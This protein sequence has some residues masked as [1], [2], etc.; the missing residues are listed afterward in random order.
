MALAVVLTADCVGQDAGFKN[1]NEQNGL[2]SSEVYQVFQDHEGF[3]W[4]ATDNGVV[5]FDGGEFKLFN[6]S[7]GLADAVVFSV[8]EDPNNKLWFKT[9]A[10]ATSIYKNGKMTPYKFNNRITSLKGTYNSIAVDSLGQV[11]V[12]SNTGFFRITNYGVLEPIKIL[13]AAMHIVQI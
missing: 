1:Y 3:I 8:I 10:G 7:N 9:F 6:K 13:P 5:K 11:Y 12:S 4:F 2:P